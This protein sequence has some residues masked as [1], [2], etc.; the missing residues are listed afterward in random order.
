MSASS[1]LL[2]RLELEQGLLLQTFPTATINPDALVVIL[3]DYRLPPG[4]SFERTDI[5][6]AIPPNYPGGQPDNICTRPDLCLA[7]GGM[8]GNNQGLQTHAG[9]QWLQFSYH[10]EPSDWHPHGDPASGSNLTD[11]LAGALTRFDEA[12]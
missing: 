6:F 7:A 1:S 9:R 2:Q 4:W 8:A 12:S 10:V 3:P 5:L 11:Y